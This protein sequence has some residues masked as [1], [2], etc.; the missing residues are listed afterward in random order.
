M[1]DIWIIKWFNFCFPTANITFPQNSKT[2]TEK[3]LREY[4]QKYLR[5][6]R[7]RGAFPH[8]RTRLVK[9]TP[10]STFLYNIDNL[11]S[12]SLQNFKGNRLSVGVKCTGSGKV[13]NID[14]RRRLSRKRR[15]VDH[16]LRVTNRKSQVADRSIASAPVI[17][18]ELS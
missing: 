18:A 4:L 15:E 3:H 6:R 14:R 13:T 16:T 10:L 17:Q 11:A 2:F 12:P 9:R 1:Y 8:D 7:S 5:K